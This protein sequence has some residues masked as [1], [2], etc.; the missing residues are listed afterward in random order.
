MV[1][2]TI[3]IGSHILDFD[4][5]ASA[6]QQQQTLQHSTSNN[7]LQISTAKIQQKVK[8]EKLAKADKQDKQEQRN[9]VNLQIL[10]SS[11]EN[12]SWTFFEEVSTL[13]NQLRGNEELSAPPANSC[14]LM[15]TSPKQAYATQEAIE[16]E[17]VKSRLD[18]PQ[19][20]IARNHQM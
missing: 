10:P 7:T 5:D 16:A 9:S 20:I 2:D 8:N 11:A 12:L 17:L 18:A 3:D 13:D 19:E 4:L 14:H 6:S 1:N 15:T